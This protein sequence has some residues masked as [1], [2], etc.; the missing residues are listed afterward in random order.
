MTELRLC[1]HLLWCSWM[2]SAL[3]NT[4]NERTTKVRVANITKSRSLLQQKMTSHLLPPPTIRFLL[5]V[6]VPDF[7][8]AALRALTRWWATSS[9][10]HHC[11]KSDSAPPPR[12]RA[13][14]YT[15]K[16]RGAALSFPHLRR[17]QRNRIW[18][19][20]S[21]FLFVTLVARFRL[22]DWSKRNMEITA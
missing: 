4:R 21:D 17:P 8:G 13:N 7:D 2:V 10:L 20:T 1:C 6:I 16:K 22:N 11:G 3:W 18:D 5:L 19:L 12:L 14:T 9:K 15:G